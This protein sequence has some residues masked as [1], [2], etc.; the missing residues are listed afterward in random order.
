MA[1]K[2]DHRPPAGLTAPDGPALPVEMEEWDIPRVPLRYDRAVIAS[3]ALTHQLRAARGTGRA[4]YYEG[5][6]AH[7][8]TA[9]PEQLLPVF[10]TASDI[11]EPE[12][13]D[14]PTD[15]MERLRALQ[16]ARAETDAQ[17]LTTE[18]INSIQARIEEMKERGKA[19]RQRYAPHPEAP[20]PRPV[21][22]DQ[23]RR[24]HA[25]QPGTGRGGPNR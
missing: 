12:V 6:T 13:G 18:Q 22:E 5:V 3:T 19:L 1:P 10:D 9:M 11:E 7:Q 17:D 16:R 20:A 25:G 23:Q 8:Q 2:V 15:Y 24:Q 21:L 14:E 4:R